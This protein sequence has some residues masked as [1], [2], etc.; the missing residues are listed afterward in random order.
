[1][2]TDAR[3]IDP[4]RFSLALEGLPI[5]NL[6]SKAAEIR[7]SIAHLKHSNEQMLP[8]A[9]EG[10][11]DCREAMFENL[12]VINRMNERIGLLRAEVEKRGMR[13]SEGE[14]EDSKMV[15]GDGEAIVVNGNRHAAANGTGESPRAPSGSLNDDELRRQLEAQMGDDEEDGVHL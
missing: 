15:N 14:V 11:D 13:W 6:H 10:D 4:A 7:N 12:T 1:M 8:F 9:D 2:S 5:E 3:P